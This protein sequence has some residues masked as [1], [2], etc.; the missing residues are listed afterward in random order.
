MNKRIVW[1]CVCVLFALLMQAGSAGAQAL[2]VLPQIDE[3]ESPRVVAKLQQL[4]WENYEANRVA[5]LLVERAIQLRRNTQLEWLDAFN[6]SYTYYPDF[7]Q[8]QGSPEIYSRFGL[9]VTVNIGRLARTPGRIRVASTDI[10]IS[11]QELEIQRKR[12]HNQ[13]IQEYAFFLE[14]AERYQLMIEAVENSSSTVQLV[15]ERFEQGDIGVEELQRAEEYL[16]QDR[17]RLIVA[18]TDF[19]KSR[20]SVQELIGVPIETI[21]E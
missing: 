1:V 6:L 20:F 4:A 12:I 8:Q 3:A 17:Q 16:I 5:E 11:K 2:N 15:R 9:G 18:R 13:V 10:D 14:S 7:L 19:F 21:F